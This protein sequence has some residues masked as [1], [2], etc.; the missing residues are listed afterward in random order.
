MG[1]GLLN[2]GVYVVQGAAGTG[3]TILANQIAFSHVAAG[4]RVAYIAL[5][6]ESHA[7]MIQHMEL[8]SFYVENAIP[9]GMHYISALTEFRGSSS[10][11]RHDGLSRLGS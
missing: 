3:K 8:F 9:R 2:G 1:G 10:Y 4:G 6:A 11:S 7:R 5:L